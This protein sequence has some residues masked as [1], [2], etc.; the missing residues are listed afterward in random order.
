[1]KSA[2]VRFG[3]PQIFITLN[4][5]DNFSPVALFYSG[6]KMDVKTFDP[7]LYSATDR[8]KTMLDNPLAVVEYFHNTVNTIVGTPLM[9]VMF[10]ELMHY[11][12]PWSIWA[13]DLLIRICW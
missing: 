4:P 3:L 9:G 11:Q 1:M 13:E 5:A 2:T 10:G 8:L 12:D 6:E 7:L